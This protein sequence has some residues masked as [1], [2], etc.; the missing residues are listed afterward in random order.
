MP[1]TLLTKTQKKKILSALQKEDC[2]EIIS[3]LESVK[4]SHAGTAKTKDKQFVITS[5]VKYVTE[6]FSGEN[7]ETK[8]AKTY[9]DAGSVFFAMPEAVAD[10]SGKRRLCLR[11]SI[12]TTIS[13]SLARRKG[14]T[15]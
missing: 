6:K 2:K 14:R 3:I 5:I 7:K 1:D 9:L 4:T 12:P 8:R 13:G 11:G 15:A 10:S